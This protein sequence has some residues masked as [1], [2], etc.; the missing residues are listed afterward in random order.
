IGF[1]SAKIQFTQPRRKRGITKNNF[2]TLYDLAMLGLTSHSKV[3]L[4]LAAM[5]GFAMSLLSLLVAMGYLAAKLIF[6]YSFPVG[7][8]PLI[9]GLFLFSSIQLLFI[10]IL[11]EYIGAIHTQILHRPLVVEKDRINF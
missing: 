5:L 7:L 8:A 2:Y 11:G 10:G 1:E 9:I 6:W 4:R 3:P